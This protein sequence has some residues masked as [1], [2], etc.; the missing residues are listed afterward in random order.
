MRI[1]D[2]RPASGA[3]RKSSTSWLPPLEQAGSMIESN[4]AACLFAIPLA[5]RSSRMSNNHDRRDLLKPDDRRRLHLVW[6][7]SRRSC[8]TTTGSLAPHT[9]HKG[10]PAVSRAALL[11]CSWSHDSGFLM[12]KEIL[13]TSCFFSVVHTFLV[14]GGR[15]QQCLLNK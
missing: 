11:H 15:S 1:A 12:I 10:G 2:H 7:K 4:G 8:Y 13:V 14:V 3:D 6:P 5:S 9:S